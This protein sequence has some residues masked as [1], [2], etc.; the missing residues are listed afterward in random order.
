MEH[1]KN[2]SV[3]SP[4]SYHIYNNDDGWFLNVKGE[5]QIGPVDSF[6][7]IDKYAKVL[8]TLE[9]ELESIV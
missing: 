8:L 9:K 2:L 5:S 1:S 6:S 7:E 3:N 4:L